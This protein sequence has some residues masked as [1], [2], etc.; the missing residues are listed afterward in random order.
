[1]TAPSANGLGFTQ[2]PTGKYA[3]VDVIANGGIEAK[4]DPALQAN[5]KLSL[6]ANN[7]L[8]VVAYVSSNGDLIWQCG[9]AKVPT[10]H[11]DAAVAVAVNATTIPAKWLPAS[12]K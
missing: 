1:M 7:T 10:L 3:L 11:I 8:D 9:L 12:C 2:L 5:S 6:A 4:F